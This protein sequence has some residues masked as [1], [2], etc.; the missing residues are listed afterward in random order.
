M[1]KLLQAANN[2]GRD[3]YGNRPENHKVPLNEAFIF[4][5]VHFNEIRNVGEWAK[6]MGYSRSHFSREIKK[7]FYKSPKILLR[8]AKLFAIVIVFLN[9]PHY[10]A[11]S[12]AKETGFDNEKSLGQ[13]LSRNFNITITEIRRRCKLYSMPGTEIPTENLSSILLDY[14]TSL[15]RKRKI[16]VFLYESTN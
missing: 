1:K 15:A 7:Y 9:D 11:F 3:F 12:I 8:N 14:L 4:L 6:K 13:F 2:V 5:F 16:V 10:K